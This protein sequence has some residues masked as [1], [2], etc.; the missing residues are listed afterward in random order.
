[1]N[2]SFTK[3]PEDYGA[4]YSDVAL[5]I[6]NGATYS[7]LWRYVF[8]MNHV[9]DFK[10]QA[11]FYSKTAVF[12]SNT[13]SRLSATKIN[14]QKVRCDEVHTVDHTHTSFNEFGTKGRFSGLGIG[15]A[16]ATCYEVQTNLN[17]YTDP[18]QVARQGAI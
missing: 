12:E 16:I 5:R 17:V 9:H 13:V 18:D 4:T 2:P 8:G 15:R 7:E 3:L 1:M 11:T 14:L 10:R 6:R